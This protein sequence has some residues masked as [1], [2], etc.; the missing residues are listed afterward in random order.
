MNTSW[1]KPT[2]DGA[3]GRAQD[4]L[5]APPAL[6]TLRPVMPERPE[7]A[8]SASGILWVRFQLVFAWVVPKSTPIQRTPDSQSKPV[9]AVPL[10]LKCE[11][12]D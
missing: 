6:I 5:G 7:V 11:G 2:E 1:L 10:G 4:A 9:S 12:P 8:G 3:T